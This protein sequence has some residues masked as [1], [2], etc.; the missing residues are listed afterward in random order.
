[1][2]DDVTQTEHGSHEQAE[3]ISARLS[4]LTIKLLERNEDY[5]YDHADRFEAYQVFMAE[6]F[7]LAGEGNFFTVCTHFDR[8]LMQAFIID[9]PIFH[10]GIIQEFSDVRQGK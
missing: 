6:S 8:F 4:F 3:L 9:K 10:R 2:N 1:M 7:R 5:F